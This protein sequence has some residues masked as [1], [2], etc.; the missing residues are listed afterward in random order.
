VLEAPNA[1]VIGGV[2]G[3]DEVNES[4]PVN[5]KPVDVKE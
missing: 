2:F 3:S 1:Q 5:E 4:E